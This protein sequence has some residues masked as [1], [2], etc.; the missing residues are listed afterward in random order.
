[1]LVVKGSST[2]GARKKSLSV[3]VW[4]ADVIVADITKFEM[5]F[6]LMIMRRSKLINK[7]IILHSSH[8][9]CYP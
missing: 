1:M 7:E 9:L 2:L 8:S 4:F 6:L 3:Y 5:H